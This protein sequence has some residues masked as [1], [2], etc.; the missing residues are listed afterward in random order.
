MGCV[1]SM[2][3]ARAASSSASNPLGFAVAGLALGV[4]GCGVGDFAVAGLGRL[5]FIPEPLGFAGLG[6]WVEALRF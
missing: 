4:C 6:S 1:M 3:C 5:G 2:A